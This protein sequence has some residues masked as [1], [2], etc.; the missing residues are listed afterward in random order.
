MLVIPSPSQVRLHGYEGR[1][2]ELEK[3]LTYRD[4]KVEYEYQKFRRA[5]WYKYK[6]GELA[7]QQKLDDLGAQRYKS[8]LFEDTEGLWTY[9]GLANGL[10]EAFDDTVKVTYTRPIG[11][12]VPWAKAPDKIPR[13]YQEVSHDNLLKAGHGGVEVGTGLGKSFVIL[14]LCKTLGLKTL[15]MSP[16][17]NI[18]QQLHDDFLLHFG[19]RWVGFFG[20]G[21]KK[22]DKLFT[23][24]IGASLTRL[25]PGSPAYQ[26]L[27]QVQVFVA[28]ESHMCPAKTLSEVC[29]GLV[30]DAPYRFFFS[31]TQIRNDGLELLLAGITGPI[32]FRMS[33]LEG[34]D[35]GF[36][37]KPVFR[38]MRVSS[39]VDY[40][41][42]DPN[43][44]TR[45]HLFY[46]P[47]VNAV[48]GEL[49]SKAVSLLGRPTVILV[50]EIE[51]FTH[52]LPY[53][54]YE[55]RFA[56][57]PLNK[58]QKALLP[59][60][61]HDSD[62]RALVTAF[63]RGEFPILVGTSCITLGTD[64]QA[65]QC[66]VFLRGGRSEIEV[67]QAVGRGTRLFPGKTDCTFF[68]FWVDN[69]P[70]LARHAKARKVYYDEIY[71]SYRETKAA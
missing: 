23:I 51:Q 62:P 47:K 67:K 20:D 12:P 43:D 27:S 38:M 59:K 6:F 63:N 31:G 26:E 52:L 3:Y 8:L 5:E 2:V 58:D 4:E 29:F 32:V 55:A 46:N 24:G 30:K 33:V 28:D 42:S 22:A 66:I 21:K 48:A 13:Y 40:A 61:Y 54:R 60:A 16:N 68:D 17:L 36:L 11:R 25:K 49:A 39:E 35:Q 34:V 10:A 45:A 44:L 18:A 9:S 53:L 41:G 15:I 1:R 56:H 50:E 57:G 71:P 64:I 7:W 37:S 69:V 65:A 19:K 70:T 14:Q